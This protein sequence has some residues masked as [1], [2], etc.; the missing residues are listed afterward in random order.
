MRAAPP[1]ADLLT[2]VTHTWG[3]G[4][5]EIGRFAVVVLWALHCSH[6]LKQGAS[7]KLLLK[8]L[9]SLH[10]RQKLGGQISQENGCVW[11]GG[12]AVAVDKELCYSFL[13]PLPI[14]LSLCLLRRL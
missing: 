14:Q 10:W 1:L 7:D 2:T 12:G 8:P 13:L 3:D 11:G 5:P 6:A 9:S 4:D